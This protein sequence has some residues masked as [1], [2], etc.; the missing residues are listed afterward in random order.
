M[1]NP[2]DIR[3]KDVRCEFED[4][5]FRAPLKFGGR[6]VDGSQVVN[7]F[8]TV[9]AADGRLAVGHGSMPLGNVWGWPT[10]RVS[11]EDTAEAVR[12]TAKA[13][14]RWLAAYPDAGHPLDIG[15]DLEHALRGLADS[16]AAEMGLPEPMPTM[17]ALV[18]ASPVDAALHD[19]YGKIHG[20]NVYECYGP[21]YV[22][23][24]LAHYLTP[25][26]RGETLDRYIQAKPQPT[27]PLTWSAP[28]T[29]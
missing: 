12:R 5:P 15:H 3:V 8:A 10:S 14:A 26:F 18:A 19:A 20:R 27:M 6:I 13:A 7:V 28:S 9:E 17:M 4:T 2:N 11:A 22:N 16:V 29:P 24:D 25:E 23:N 21:P 1:A